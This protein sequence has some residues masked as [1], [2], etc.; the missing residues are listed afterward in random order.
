LLKVI[1]RLY[2]AIAGINAGS[3]AFVECAAKFKR[4]MDKWP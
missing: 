1:A 2:L 3:D 4:A